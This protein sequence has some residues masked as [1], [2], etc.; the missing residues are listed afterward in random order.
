MNDDATPNAVDWMI[1]VELITPV[2]RSVFFNPNLEWVF[3]E[4]GDLA[5]LNADFH[6][7]LETRAGGRSS[8]NRPGRRD[9]PA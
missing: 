9:A 5:T 2:T 6:Y 7:D 8:R 1:G 3:V 4:G